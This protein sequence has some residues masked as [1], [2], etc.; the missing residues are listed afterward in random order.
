MGLLSHGLAVGIGYLLGRPDGR[1]RLAQAGRQAADLAQ[2]PEVAR[3]RERGK[4]L[5]ASQ[6]Q[7]VKQKITA[8]SK[9]ADTDAPGDGGTAVS[10]P[11]PG[12]RTSA[13]R[14]RFRRSGSAHFPS[15]EEVAP[16]TAGVATAGVA[17]AGVGTSAVEESD[18]ADQAT[19][20]VNPT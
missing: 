7:T 9:S 13:W 14:S 18:V 15:S 19:A 11:L 12:L 4:D 3:I 1:A 2:R 20:R 5:A 17:T 16:A 10:D 6:A 8:R